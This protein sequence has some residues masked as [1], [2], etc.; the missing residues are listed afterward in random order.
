[1]QHLTYFE[2]NSTAIITFSRSH[3][4]NALNSEVFAELNALL[5]KIEKSD[6]I[7]VVVLT[8]KGKAFIAGADIAEMKGKT[9]KEAKEFSK[10]GQDTFRRI[11]NMTIP[12]IGAINGFALG[13]GLET[14]LACDF[15][16]ASDKAKF[17]APEVNLGLIPGFAGTQRLV[18]AIG[19]NNA[20]FYLFTAHMFDAYDA[21]R[22]G[23][24]QQ[25]VPD[26]ELMNET[27]KIAD[28][29][30]TKGPSACKALKGVVQEGLHHGIDAGIK[31]ENTVFG[32]LFNTEAKEGMLAFLE[33]RQAKW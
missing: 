26:D 28:L 27:M 33:K 23:L 32:S 6:H 13:G 21:Q 18:R 5:N 3:A 16:V 22:M 1:M 14:A 24:V 2:N 7:R 4:L 25:I 12:F 20:R 31:K 11:E 8:G 10:T 29:I 9:E 30:A 17:S 19:A 15:L